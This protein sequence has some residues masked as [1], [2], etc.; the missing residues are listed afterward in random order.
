MIGKKLALSI[1]AALFLAG[2][3][4]AQSKNADKNPPV[5]GAV[6]QEAP[7]VNPV[8][9]DPSG[10]GLAVPNSYVIGPEDIIFISVY[11]EEGISHQYGVRPD[12][13]ITVPLIKDVQAAGLTPEQL[14]ANI[15]KSLT[16]F[17][18][19]PDVVVS[20]LQ[21]N[22]KKYF[23]TGEVSRPG[24]YPLVTPVT[25]FEA[26]NG[27]GGFR[28]FANRKNIIVMRGSQRIKFN[29]EDILKGKHL[30]TNIPVQNNDTIAIK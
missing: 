15:T 16:E 30:E 28:D 26:I 19:K 10:N 27:A 23:I 3:L 5:E 25:V 18:N 13:K 21:V 4:A 11:R 9:N 1:S 2:S 24:Q 22:S 29:Y 8:S 6:K 7:R 12:G 17:I 20:V 14:G